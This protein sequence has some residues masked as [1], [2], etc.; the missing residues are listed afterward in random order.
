M[1]VPSVRRST[2]H[3]FGVGEG[4]AGSLVLES[5]R[6]PEAGGPASA[7]GA[8]VD[9]VPG[10]GCGV[11]VVPVAVA[12]SIPAVAGGTSLAGDAVS[13]VF[14]Q[15]AVARRAMTTAPA[16]GRRMVMARL[17]GVSNQRGNSR[18]G[19]RVVLNRRTRPPFPPVSA[20]G[21]RRSETVP[22]FGA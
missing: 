17:L 19:S 22:L 14:E 15:A 13:S 21:A 9:E 10:A 16:A 3:C 11:A 1:I 12:S 20:W 5:A 6:S 8:L 7:A 4:V 2:H 18:H